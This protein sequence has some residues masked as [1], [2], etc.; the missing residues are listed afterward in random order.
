MLQRQN[1]GKGLYVESLEGTPCYTSGNTYG[2]KHTTLDLQGT[3]DA[4]CRIKCMAEHMV[5]MN[6]KI[7]NLGTVGPDTRVKERVY[8][9][10]IYCTSQDSFCYIGVYVL[11]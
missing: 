2:A 1:D 3:C 11:L 8:A 4:W 5:D 10:L 7:E 9:F 6:S